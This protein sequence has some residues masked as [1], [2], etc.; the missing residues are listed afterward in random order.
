M[1]EVYL[2]CAVV[3]GTIFLC[4]LVL[5]LLGMGGEHDFSDTGHDVGHDHG[6][7]H[8]GAFSHIF[9]LRA[10]IAPV[11]FF[12]LTGIAT[13]KSGM[14]PMLIAAASFAA[15]TAGLFV[16]GLLMSFVYR[17]QADGTAHIEQALGK[18]GTVYLTI[19]PRMGGSGKVT[20]N[21]QNRTMEYLAVTSAGELQ[22]GSKI[23]V[24]D[25]VSP[26]TVAVASVPEEI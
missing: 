4:Q 25:I 19:P 3:G 15:G 1:N 5:S 17:L 22:S 20:L 12:G 16:V 13:S 11:T 6:H 26:D 2:V 18:T 10:I 7:D 9:S 14:A 24:V 21:V 8:S 23:V